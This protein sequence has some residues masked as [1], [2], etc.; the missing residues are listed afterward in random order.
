MKAAVV[1][2]GLYIAF[3]LIFVGLILVTPIVAFSN[4]DSARLL[5]QG[6]SFTCH[7][8]LSRSICLFEDGIGDCIEQTGEFVADDREEISAER[9]GVIGYKFPVC[10]RDIG[11]YGFMLVGAI[12]YALLFSLDEKRIFPPVLLVVAIIPIALDGGI[13]FLSDMGVHL[14]GFEYESTNMIRLITGGIAGI[15]VSFYAL[16]I[17]NRMFGE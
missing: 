12:V 3:L 6:F 7:Q 10:S 15:A 1:V 13:Q 4:E 14:L 8:K 17:L 9:S 16:P 11:L 5:Y 2:Y